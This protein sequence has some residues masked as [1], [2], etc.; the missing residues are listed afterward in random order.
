FVLDDDILLVFVFV[1][2]HQVG[3]L[4]QP[5]FGVD[6]LHVD[7]VMGILVQL[8]EA[9]ALRRAGRGKHLHRAAYQAQPYMALPTRS[10]C[11]SS[12]PTRTYC[13]NNAPI[14]APDPVPTH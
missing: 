6:R 1:A 4:D 7:A 10:G 2:A 5:Q 11:H 12:S 3:S 14:M 9:D 13:R 8:V